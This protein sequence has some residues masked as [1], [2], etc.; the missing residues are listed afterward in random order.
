MPRDIAILSALVRSDKSG[1]FLR[2]TGSTD[3]V[4]EAFENDLQF[5]RLR[6]VR[7]CEGTEK[8]VQSVMRII[9]TEKGAYIEDRMWGSS[10]PT[11]IGG[12]MDNERFAATRQSVIDALTH[13]NQVN[14]DNPNSD[15]VISTIDELQVVQDLDD[16]RRMRIVVGFTTESGQSVRVTVPQV[17]E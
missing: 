6:Q 5:D 17:S 1:G 7:M 10:A 12:K 8:L 16:P 11:N 15:E 9:L 4:F 3:F 13:Y 2:A 14:Y